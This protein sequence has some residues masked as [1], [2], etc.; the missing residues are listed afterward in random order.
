MMHSK[1]ILFSDPIIA[2][3]ILKT[4]SPKTQKALG[5][6]VKNFNEKIWMAN[7]ERIVEEGNYWK[8]V[9]GRDEGELKDGRSLKEKLLETGDRE[10]VEA[11]PMDRIWGVGFGEKNAESR[12]KDWGF[13]LL[14][15]ALMA[16]RERI[17]KEEEGATEAV[18][19]NEDKEKE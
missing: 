16:V 14:G 13:N 9:G 18:E 5:R 3:K 15:K 4:T 10:I 19:E 2:A 1:A 6:Q 11:S 7:R 12:R 17:R 8:Y